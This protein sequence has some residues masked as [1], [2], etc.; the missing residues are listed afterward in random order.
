MLGDNQ[1][2]LAQVSRYYNCFAQTYCF[3]AIYIIQLLLLTE[4]YKFPKE[5]TP[6]IVKKYYSWDTGFFIDEMNNLNVDAYHAGA[7]NMLG[8]SNPKNSEVLAFS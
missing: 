7:D 3:G 4:A 2:D 6:L 1:P 8:R 5:A